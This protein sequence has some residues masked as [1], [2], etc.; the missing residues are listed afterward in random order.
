[1]AATMSDQGT[2]EPETLDPEVMAL[3]DEIAR[4][5]GSLGTGEETDL[6]LYQLDAAA[7]YD[8]CCSIF[9][10]QPRRSPVVRG[11]LFQRPREHE[12]RQVTHSFSM[13]GSLSVA[14]GQ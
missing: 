7:I 3:A 13:T 8:R 6:Q 14:V 10:D 4:M 9:P 5:A 1:M 11:D 2:E 12:L